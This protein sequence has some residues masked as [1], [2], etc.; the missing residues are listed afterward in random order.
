MVFEA[1]IF[2]WRGTL[3]RT[4]S[5]HVGILSDIHFDI[6]FAFQAAGILDL[7]DAFCLSYELGCQKSGPAIF[8]AALDMLA[9]AAE[10]ALMVGN[11]AKPYGAA[12]DMGMTT[13][14]LPS[15][16]EVSDRRLHRVLMLSGIAH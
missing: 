14:L 12:V 7:I 3:V 11:R 4:Q 2:D 5:A 1:V 8:H 13:L 9:T 15:L 6:R 16:R 10:N